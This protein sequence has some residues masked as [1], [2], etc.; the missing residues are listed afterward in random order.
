MTGI[1]ALQARIDQCHVKIEQY[2]QAARAARAELA[3]YT[4]ALALVSNGCA[5]PKPPKP[6]KVDV[7]GERVRQVLDTLPADGSPMRAGEVQR[8]LGIT[9][10]EFTAVGRS[11]EFRAVAVHGP[12]GYWR[13]RVPR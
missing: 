12:R 2:E 3:A 6:D 8:A 11:M 10:N 7:V 5:T 1:E 4:E 13:L 9:Q